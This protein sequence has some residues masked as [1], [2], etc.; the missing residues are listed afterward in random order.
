MRK[1]AV[2]TPLLRDVAWRF[3]AGES[4]DAGLDVVRDLDRRGARG[5]LNH[6][7]TH[8][9][10][11][12]GCV[13]AT[14]AIVDTVRAIEAAAVDCQVSIKLTQIG[15]DVDVDLCLVQLDRIMRAA[16]DASVFVCID[17]EESVYVDGTL[18]VFE[19]VRHRY[20]PDAVGIVVQ[21]YLRHRQADLDRL[22][23]GSSRVRLVKGGYW[24]ASDVVFRGEETDRAFISDI[25][26]LLRG[27]VE[28][29]IATHDE[30]AIAKTKT[31]AALLGLDKDA[32]DFQMLYGVR[33]DLRDRLIGEGYRVRCYVPFGDAWYAYVLGCLRSVVGSTVHEVRTRVPRRA[34]KRRH[35]DEP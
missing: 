17:M 18:A 16:H 2:S 33:H 11:E 24:E 23:E 27:G 9:R 12:P 21:S 8:V 28:P 13:A 7:G 31:T 4:L 5:S 20:G 1:A 14:D 32:F 3:V 22:M 15:L 26:R 19:D 6:L 30:R 25:E 35:R 34:S 10:H 29:A